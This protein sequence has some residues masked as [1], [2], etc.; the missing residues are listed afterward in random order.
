MLGDQY[1]LTVYNPLTGQSKIVVV[2]E[3][4]YKEYRRGIWRMK[5]G[6]RIFHKHVISFSDLIGDCER[7]RE[8]CSTDNDPAL[9]AEQKLLHQDLLRAFA[10]LP[11]EDRVLL[12]AIFEE[13]R[14][15][16]DIAA[17]LGVSQTVISRRKR[18]LIQILK[19]YLI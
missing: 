14:S 7:F 3:A 13:G 4:V 17:Q 18:R 6:D 15:E 16:C 1:T 19:K 9:L 10:L 12:R 8:L 11:E 5:S 2:T